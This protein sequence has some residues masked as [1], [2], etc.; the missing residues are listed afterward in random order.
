MP[1]CESA[2]AFVRLN[3]ESLHDFMAGKNCG[4]LSA[5]LR[6]RETRLQQIFTNDVYKIYR[7]TSVRETSH[8][9]IAIVST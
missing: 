1:R 4:K 5:T 2:D 9:M 3:I 7:D 8:K 6:D